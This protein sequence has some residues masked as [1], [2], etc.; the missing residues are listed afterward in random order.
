MYATANK[1]FIPFAFVETFVPTNFMQ[2][3]IP[4]SLSTLAKFTAFSDE[5][6]IKFVQYI[7]LLSRQALKN[8]PLRSR[9]FY[10]IPFAA[11]FINSRYLRQ[12]TKLDFINMS[13]M[14]SLRS[15]RNKLCQWA[16]F[17][18][19]HCHGSLSVEK[20]GSIVELSWSLL[21]QFILKRYQ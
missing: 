2:L 10:C 8:I 16:L 4:S 3:M 20:K 1:F 14:A 12:R 5:I 7:L 15:S 17:N 6:K 9:S 11:Y 21:C 13:D 19:T 18:L